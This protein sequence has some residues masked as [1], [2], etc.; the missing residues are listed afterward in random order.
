MKLVHSPPRPLLVLPNV[1]VHPSTASV[2]ITVLLYNGPLICGFYALIIL[3]SN[4]GGLCMYTC[5]T[6]DDLLTS[7]FALKDPE[8]GITIAQY[9]DWCTGHWWK[10]VTHTTL[11]V[12]YHFAGF[13][14]ALGCITS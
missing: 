1:T 7:E 10:A 8:L 6:T 4:S 2:Q 12:L 14:S 9:C 3:L 5:N 11:L 13:L